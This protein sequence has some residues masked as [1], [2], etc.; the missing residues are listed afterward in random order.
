MKLISSVTF[1][2]STLLLLLL[3][4]QRLLQSGRPLS[5]ASRAHQEKQV[6]GDLD[7]QSEKPR[8]EPTRFYA[9]KE[10]GFTFRYPASGQLSAMLNTRD[11]HNGRQLQAAKVTF[12]QTF[13]NDNGQGRDEVV[14]EIAVYDNGQPLTAKQWPLTQW[15]PDVIR[16][17]RSIKLNGVQGYKVTVFEIDRSVDRIYFVKGSRMYRLSYWAP[18]SMWDFTPEIRRSYARIFDR[19]LRSFSLQ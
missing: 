13:K 15:E 4:G 9:S 17:E 5:Q 14:F 1:F 11:E 8:E 16:E 12:L 18:D 19:I 10:F 7:S 6:D 3:T 2:V